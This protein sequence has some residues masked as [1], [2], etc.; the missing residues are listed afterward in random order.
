MPSPIAT[1][2]DSRLFALAMRLTLTFVFWSSGLAKLFDFTNNAAM[3]ESFGLTPGWAFNIATLTLQIG[4]SA[5]IVLN[6]G[7]W[8]A[9]G[10]LAAFTLLTIP[11][12]HPFWSLTGEEAFLAMT[13]AVEHISL[14]AGLALAAILSR[15]GDQRF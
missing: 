1:L 4:A 6:R 3:M 15:K 2:L 9:A 13:V 14:C 12:V 10:A 7:V 5:M 8:L 11:I